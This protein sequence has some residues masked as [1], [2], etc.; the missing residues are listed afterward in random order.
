MCSSISY[1]YNKSERVFNYSLVFY[2]KRCSKVPDR[3]KKG[4]VKALL[5]SHRGFKILKQDLS[6][7][8]TMTNDPNNSNNAS[9][10][11]KDEVSCNRALQAIINM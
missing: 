9:M 1:A 6:K 11:F 10:Y 8:I 4:L 2:E 7:G 3:I 5:T